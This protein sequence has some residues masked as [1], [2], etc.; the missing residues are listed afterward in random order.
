MGTKMI[1]TINMTFR[2]MGLDEAL[3]A[4]KLSPGSMLDGRR[5]GNNPTT[6]KKV[7]PMMARAEANQALK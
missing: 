7:H 5:L 3:K 1:V 4:V 6:P 2:V